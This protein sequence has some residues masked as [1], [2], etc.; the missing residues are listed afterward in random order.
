MRHSYWVVLA[1]VFCIVSGESAALGLTPDDLK[2]LGEDDYEAKTQALDR[3]IASG[4]KV[5]LRILEALNSENVVA[6]EDD[7]VLIQDGNLLRD[8][9]TYATIAASDV[10]PITLNNTLRARVAGGLSGLRLQASD[11]TVR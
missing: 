2:P 4:D 7:K 8:P 1:I 9:I 3:I 5:A 11:R 6:T 10:Q